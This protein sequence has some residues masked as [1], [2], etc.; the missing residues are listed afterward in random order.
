M[1]VTKIDQFSGHRDCIYTLV[2]GIKED[3][4]FSAGGDGQV[5]KWSLQKPDLGKL[6]A[7][8]P[9]TI[10]ALAVDYAQNHLWIGQN[11]EGINRIDLANNTQHSSLKLD[12]GAIFDIKINNNL[13]FVAMHSGMVYVI[14]IERFII[15]KKILATHNSARTLAIC[16]QLNHLAVGYSDHVIRIFDLTTFEL[17]YLLKG[18]SNSVFT[19]QYSHTAQF[20]IS[21]G[22]DAHLRRWNVQEQYA[23]MEAI[24]AH[25]YAI[26]HI[27]FSPNNK[28]LATASMDKSIKI[29]DAHTLKLLKVVDKAR[30]AGHGTSINKLIWSNF[31]SLLV[32]GSDDRHI[33]IWQLKD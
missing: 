24:P 5:V 13:A 12:G 28:L 22:R 9:S 15:V 2:Q 25:L 33:S 18:H 11:Q 32:A 31:K 21:A 10:Y 4:F 16:S 8:V 19:L 27:V 20:L 7:Q 26:N 3:E 14:D 17:K 23:P 6:V 29:W 1:Q 30:H